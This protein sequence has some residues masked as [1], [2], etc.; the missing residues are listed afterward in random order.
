MAIDDTISRDER[1]KSIVTLIDKTKEML[2]RCRDFSAESAFVL[3]AA[4]AA[5]PARAVKRAYRETKK[6][7]EA[8]TP[9]S[10]YKAALTVYSMIAHEIERRAILTDEQKLQRTIDR[11][12]PQPLRD[13]PEYNPETGHVGAFALQALADRLIEEKAFESI[14][15]VDQAAA[16]RKYCNRGMIADAYKNGR[17]CTANTYEGLAKLVL[18]HDGNL[19]T[20]HEVRIRF[21]K[22]PRYWSPTDNYV[23]G[24]L[25]NCPD[26]CTAVV[27]K[28][29]PH[30]RIEVK[31]IDG[32]TRQY[33]EAM[34]RRDD[35]PREP[36]DIIPRR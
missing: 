11:N 17:D 14:E 19:E 29:L 23:Q 33:K 13:I 31:R 6:D 7:P 12:R 25:I 3:V 32:E 34:P 26:T 5:M 28:K 24:Q 8:Q 16:E 35:F 22:F 21:L 4:E 36:A 15:E 2:K 1:K 10:L 20:T 9:E 18:E 27:T 30:Q